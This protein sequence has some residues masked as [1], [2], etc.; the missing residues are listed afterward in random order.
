[1]AVEQ[2]LALE[3]EELQRL[4]R[5]ARELRERGERGVGPALDQSER[6]NT[7]LPAGMRPWRRSKRRMSDTCSGS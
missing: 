4:D 7:T 3:V 1:V 2:D 6:T 5:D